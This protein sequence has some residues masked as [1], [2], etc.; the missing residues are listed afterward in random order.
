M[1]EEELTF[2]ERKVLY[3]L[4][5]EQNPEQ[6]P[7]IR[8]LARK[9]FPGFRPWTTADRAVRNSLRRLVAAEFV[10]RAARGIYRAKR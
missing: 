6:A 7:T 3:A 5:E 4:R 9:C 1:K 2:R 10:E 8:G